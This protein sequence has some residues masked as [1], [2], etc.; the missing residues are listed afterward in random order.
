MLKGAETLGFWHIGSEFE[1][2]HSDTLGTAKALILLGFWQFFFVRKSKGNQKGN[3][4]YVRL[5]LMK[6]EYL[7]RMIKR[8][9]GSDNDD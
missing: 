1:S 7:A 8:E 3:Q 2:R 5:T 4:T 6:G 9:D